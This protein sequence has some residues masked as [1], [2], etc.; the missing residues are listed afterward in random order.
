MEPGLFRIM[1]RGLMTNEVIISRD[2]SSETK[3]KY[4]IEKE[5]MKV[6]HK[7]QNAINLMF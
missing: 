3:I 6:K 5:N 1:Q 4:Q 7:I 2:G